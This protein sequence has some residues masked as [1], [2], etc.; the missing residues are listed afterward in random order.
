METCR[1]VVCFLKQINMMKQS[2]QL[3]DVADF[4]SLDL[5]QAMRQGIDK[6]FDP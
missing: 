2:H 5:F 1:D 4:V 3:C 6:P